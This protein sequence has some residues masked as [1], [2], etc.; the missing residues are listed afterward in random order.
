MN[1]AELLVKC[2]EKEEVT[3]IFGLPGE[4]NLDIMEALSHS[5][6]RF[7][8]TR[9]EQGAAFIAD[10]YGRLTGKA[11]VCLATL[12]P[13]ATNLMT[14]VADANMDRAPLVA[15]TGQAG[16]ER[17]H[18]ESHQYI[19]IVSMFK[20][21][22][23][24]NA[25]VEKG[26]LVPEMVRKAFKLA[27]SEKPG[28]CHIELPEDIAAEQVEEYYLPKS[29]SKRPCPDDLVLDRAA[30]LIAASKQPIILS[31][32]G[33]I[34]GGAAKELRRFVEKS[35]IPVAETF[36][37]KGSIS[38]END[39]SLL[40]IG[41]QAN[42][43]V[44]CGFDKADLVITIGYDIVEYGPKFWNPRK[45]KTIIHIDS[46]LSEVDEYYSPAV[47]ISADISETLRLLSERL[48]EPKKCTY[49]YTLRDYIKRDLEE[50][51]ENTG[52]PVK[53]QKIL[54]DLRSVMGPED[55]VI[56]DV[57][58]HKMWVARMYPAYEPNTV[59]ISNGFASMGISLPGAIAAKLAY[60]ERK[61]VAVCG[62]GAF[63][64]NSQE[65]ET[66]CR[67]NLPIVTMI[68]NDGA[69]GLIGWKQVRKYGKD[70]G[71]SFGNPDFKKYAESFGA[72]G[73][74]VECASELVPILEDAFRQKRPSVIDI[75]VD[76]SENLKLTEKL[77]KTICPI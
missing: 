4:E 35:Q 53:P 1:A 41:L 40:S 48:G 71:I 22:T 9:H 68:W 60:P 55:I 24:W 38:F 8:P 44:S 6:I 34:R 29:I 61:V 33:V 17:T 25:R 32:N 77:G 69:Y 30:E 15:I 57:G 75:P 10:V 74:R 63:L 73:Y 2:L 36:M 23:K 27:E 11:G 62:D 31:G 64:L 49:N 28:A 65:L 7:I 42:D 21:I 52:C 56:S 3:D 39:L 5:S 70:F 26:R 18:K 76:Y 37:G 72:V 20:P 67:L 51:R 16:L 13:G 58:A 12:G 14:G 59:I 46:T 43:Y 47:E 66:A 45:D 19:D 50:H 54:W